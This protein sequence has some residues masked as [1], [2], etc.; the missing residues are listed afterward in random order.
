MLGRLP[1]VEQ[2]GGLRSVLSRNEV[3][4]NVMTRAA[5]LEL[6][7][8]YVTAGWIQRRVGE[9]ARAVLLAAPAAEN[10]RSGMAI[11][12]FLVEGFRKDWGPGEG[13]SHRP[14]QEHE[15]DHGSQVGEVVGGG[16]QPADARC[17]VRA[18][19]IENLQ[20]PLLEPEQVLQR[21]P[22]GNNDRRPDGF[23][24]LCTAGRLEASNGT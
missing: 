14:G 8:W 18:D 11:L 4:T 3:L 2:L 10:R 15:A 5:M 19:R 12:G 7:G 20:E 17:C 16:D 24:E 22:V 23:R 1:L 21:L 13:P 6:P 9:G